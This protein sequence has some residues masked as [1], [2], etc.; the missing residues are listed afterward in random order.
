[1]KATT[2]TFHGDEMTQQEGTI[3]DLPDGRTAVFRGGR[4]VV[5]SASSG[6]NSV[7][8]G[9][10]WALRPMQ[11]PSDRRAD[12]AARR[13]EDAAARAERRE[14]RLIG[15]D[16]REGDR[17]ARS[18]EMDLR[19]EYNA[20]PEVKN[21]RELRTSFQNLQSAAASGTAAGDVKLIFAY[22]KMLDPTSVVR[23]GE[24]ATAEQTGGIP[25]QVRNLYNKALDGQR[26]NDRMRANFVE[27]AYNNYQNA[28]GA[29]KEAS[30]YYRGLADEY[31]YNADRIVRMDEP[32][33]YQPPSVQGD[34]S[35]AEAGGTAE[36][37]ARQP[38]EPG[39]SQDNPIRLDFENPDSEEGINATR[40]AA[41]HIRAGDWFVS[42]DE[43]GRRTLKQAA[44]D[45]YGSEDAGN[46]IPGGVRLRTVGLA[47]RIGAASQAATEQIPFGDEL[48]AQ[49]L[50]VVT[51]EGYD[52]IRDRQA[53]YARIDNQSQRGSRIAGG[54]GG[55]GLTMLAPGGVATGRYIA[56]A[57]S[58]A[59]T[60]G[61]G[62]MVGAG[63]GAV[64]GAGAAD[65]GLGNRI[66]GAQDGMMTGAMTGGVL[67][68]GARGAD[69]LW[70]AAR[71][72]AGDRAQSVSMLRDNGVFLTPGQRTGG[73]AKSIE[74]LMARA[75]IVG[76]AIRGA[77][78]RARDS[79]ARGSVRDDLSHIGEDLPDHIPA[80]GEAV[81]Y[82][83]QRIGAQFDRA[84]DMVGETALDEAFDAGLEAIAA[85]GRT[86]PT[87]QLEQFTRIIED[88]LAPLRNGPVNGQSLREVQSQLETIAARYEKSSDGAQRHLAD[89][90]YGVSDEL[91]GVM[92]RANPDV[93]DVLD[94]A[95]RAWA[96]FTRTRRASAAAGGRPFTPQ[97]LMTA[98]RQEDGSV[99]KGSVARATA[100]KQD[101]ARAGSDVMPDGF[102]NP[103]TAD[104][105]GLGALG[106]GFITEPITTTGVAA[107]LAAA[108]TPYF[109]M[110]R[111]VLDRVASNPS[112]Q[113]VA[114]AEQELATLA[115]SD[116]KVI[117]LTD[118]LRRI[119]QGSA[120]VAATNAPSPQ[121]LTTGAIGLMTGAIAGR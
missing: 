73:L 52:A 53:T 83:A 49:G 120:G 19:K 119:Y 68:G 9:G 38:N 37:L 118:E 84:R 106:V 60:V 24:F 40:A 12:E 5:Q 71:N 80:G 4:W 48:L 42:W 86:L 54:I 94:P 112:R 18:E 116:P 41:S 65:G 13:A 43:D 20:L 46:A 74:D 91:N 55:A 85:D 69:R 90:L 30:E 45:A 51:G 34:A 76:T 33:E 82:A 11:T 6:G 114:E 25:D 15:N 8:V 79:F 98:V 109:A 2:Y 35:P 56:S 27:Q 99:G 89:M 77:R 47:D 93:A 87:S 92:Q 44:S 10:G 88:R 102:G 70:G 7:D 31:G 59:T 103:G 100:L 23:E 50:G 107:G 111:K 26:L 62:M 61:R 36:R 113:A 64:Y 104:A 22:M 110:G 72:G 3:A 58:L 16:E 14:E 1:M 63:T 39:Y 97:Q 75:P 81:D 66:Q 29:Y 17:K 115:R 28:Y 95:R 78:E 67:A 96:G 121:R 21:Y 117:Q 108:A 101:Y 32:L 57:P 105:A